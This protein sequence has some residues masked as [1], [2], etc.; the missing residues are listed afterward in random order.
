M[1]NTGKIKIGDVVFVYSQPIE[2][3]LIGVV[4][5]LKYPILNVS[6]IP[7]EKNNF[8]KVEKIDIS[9]NIPLT[10]FTEENIKRILT[11]KEKKELSRIEKDREIVDLFAESY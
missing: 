6:V 1:I 10:I 5:S 2:E 8:S 7:R 3:A 11:K 4:D 9:K